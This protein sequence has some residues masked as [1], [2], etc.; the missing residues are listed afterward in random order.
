MDMQLI[1]DQNFIHIEQITI[2]IKITIF[3]RVLDY[4]QRLCDKYVLF[5]MDLR[6]FYLVKGMRLHVLEFQIILR[7][8]N[9]S[10][11]NLEARII[12]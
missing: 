6:I 1:S 8:L 11:H 3:T 5:H 2:F 4:M 10:D 9:D 12:G 7:I